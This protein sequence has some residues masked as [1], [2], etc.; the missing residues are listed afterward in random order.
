MRW[1]RL[2]YLLA[3]ERFADALRVFA[4]LAGVMLY[5]GLGDNV[6]ELIPLMLGV[7]AAAIAETDDSWRRRAS[8]LAVRQQLIQ[9][10][11]STKLR[12]EC[13]DVLSQ[14]RVIKIRTQSPHR[15]RD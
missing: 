8:A 2:Q 9:R 15:Q 11:P 12:H 10:H 4:A 1:H 5:A 13:L 6:H 3:F 14:N 7:I